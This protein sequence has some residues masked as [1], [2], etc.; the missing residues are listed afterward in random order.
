[1]ILSIETS[2]PA[3]SIALHREGKLLAEQSYY[4]EKSH[5][6]LL[7][8]IIEELLTNTQVLRNELLAVSISAGPGSYTG[9]RIGISAA[10]GLC[11]ALQIP[12]ISVNSLDALIEQAR[13]WVQDHTLIAP[14]IDARRM[15]VYTKLVSSSG[16]EV[17]P[18][19][20]LIISKHIFQEFEGKKICVLGSGSE[21]CKGV[22]NHSDIQ[23][24]PFR[25][26]SA[27]DSGSIAWS[28]YQ[29]KDFENLAYFEPNYLKEF[30][31][32]KRT[33]QLLT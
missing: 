4:S 31:T 18:V 30:Q 9:L 2:T 6:V 8:V 26:P 17:W 23:F 33:N 7:P 10:K 15:E 27:A 3:C 21:K 32:K 13:M 5:S 24:I 16:E 12:L 1:M 20:P 28:K 29:N 22:L 11:F 19:K 25:H 14:M